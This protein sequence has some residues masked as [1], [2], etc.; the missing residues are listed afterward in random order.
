M[1][2]IVSLIIRISL[3]DIQDMFC[4]MEHYATLTLGEHCVNY[5]TEYDYSNMIYLHITSTNLYF[6]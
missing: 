2:Q 4:P 1:N 5:Y 3:L 6:E